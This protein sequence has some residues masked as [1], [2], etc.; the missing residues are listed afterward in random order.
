MKI[1]DTIIVV[2]HLVLRK[3]NDQPASLRVKL[4]KI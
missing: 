3:R 2:N 4:V 1:I